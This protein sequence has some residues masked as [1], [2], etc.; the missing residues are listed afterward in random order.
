MTASL[1]INIAPKAIL[2]PN[3]GSGF[4][5]GHAQLE[6]SISLTLADFPKGKQDQI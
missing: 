1:N 3:N 4:E 2:F 5:R 6:S